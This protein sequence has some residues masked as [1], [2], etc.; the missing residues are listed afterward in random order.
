MQADNFSLLPYQ[1]EL[2]FI[3]KQALFSGLLGLAIFC[4]CYLMPGFPFGEKFLWMV[5]ALSCCYLAT[6][7]LL[8]RL[9]KSSYQLMITGLSIVGLGFMSVLVH[10]SGGIASPLVFIYFPIL[11]SEAAYGGCV[12]YSTAFAVVAYVLVI[13]AEYF[14]FLPSATVSAREIY[15]SAPTT[16]GIGMFVVSFLI[17]SGSV[18]KLI[19]AKLRTQVAR[20]NEEKHAVISK[21]SELEAHSQIGVLAHRIAHDLRGPISSISGYLQIEMLNAKNPDDKAMLTEIN[22]IV[23][24]MSASLKGI[25]EFGRAAVPSE[26]IV[27]SDFMRTLL[28]IISYSPQTRNVKFVKLYP[29]NL[30]LSVCA[31]R[32]DLQQVY[33]NLIRNAVEAIRDNSGSKVIEVSI[34]AVENDVEVSIS[35][36]GPGMEPEVLK[37]LFRKSI[38]TKKDGTG[39]GLVITRDLLARNGGDIEFHNLP[40]GG[41]WVA[42]RLPASRQDCPPPRE[43]RK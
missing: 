36:N 24:G 18:V 23:L 8:W 3:R 35:D 14:G 2:A 10:L 7:L 19:V 29:E 13:A 15:A 37:N 39:V 22:D 20:E 5:M 11:I 32:A 4:I 17:I 9:F 16:F 28:A 27:L 1:G 34:K 30:K 42:T 43:P 12:V 21:L 33:F 40:A 31:S 26:T 25:T 6:Y 41:L 38:T